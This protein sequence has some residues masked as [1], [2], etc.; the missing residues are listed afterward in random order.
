MKKKVV[1]VLIVTG[2]ILCT[3]GISISS[4]DVSA[5]NDIYNIQF[6]RIKPL[7][8]PADYIN[9]YNN[10]KSK[11][12]ST[13]DKYNSVQSFVHTKDK[14]AF[15]LTNT[16][17]DEE[18]KPGTN[19]L[20]VMCKK[21]NEWYHC[22][23]IRNLSYGH[24]NDMAYNPHDNTIAIVFR[25]YKTK[26]GTIALLDAN[27][28]KEK[29]R[30]K[31]PYIYSAIAYDKSLKRYYLTRGTIKEKRRF[32]YAVC[33][34][35][36]TNCKDSVFSAEFKAV[37]SQ[38]MAAANGYI[39]KINYDAGKNTIYQ[40]GSLLKYRGGEIEVYHYDS[41]KNKYNRVR[42]L[43]FRANQQGINMGEIEGMDFNGDIPYFVFNDILKVDG[44]NTMGRIYTPKYT[45]RNVNA[46]VY[47]KVKTNNKKNFSKINA[48]A[49][50]LSSNPSINKNIAFSNDGYTLSNIDIRTP[51]TYTFKIKQG[52]IKSN[53]WKLD[54]STKTATIR[55]TYSLALNNLTY[56][57][58]FSKG[59]NVFNNNYVYSPIEVPV[60]VNVKTTKKDASYKTPSTKATLYKDGKKIETVSAINGKYTFKKLKF[61]KKGTYKYEIKQEKSGISK[62]GIFTNTIDSS[63]ID[64]TITITEGETVFTTNTKYSKNTFVNKVD[65]D[66]NNVN[67]KVNVKIKTTKSDSEVPTP[68]TQATITKDKT[69]VETVNSANNSYEF[70]ISIKSPGVYKYIIKQNTS[71]T[72]QGI[73]SY[74]LDKTSIT[75][76]ITSK[77]ENNKLVCTSKLSSNTFTNKIAANYEEISVPI[78][79]KIVTQKIPST[80]ETPSTK[81]IIKIGNT[82]KTI[83]NE[84]QY[85]NY[86]AKI[87][88]PGIY[89]Y[90][91]VQKDISNTTD[92]IFD[93]DSKTITYNITVTSSNGILHY[94][95]ESNNDS[96]NNTITSN[97]N[98]LNLSLAIRIETSLPQGINAPITQATL[99]SGETAISTVN[100]AKAR[101]TFNNI[102][103]DT[104]GTYTYKIKQQQTGIVTTDKYIYEYD[105]SEIIVTIIVTEENDKLKPTITYSKNNFNNSVNY[106]YDSISVP[107]KVNIENEKDSASIV[108]PVTTA[109]IYENDEK[110][111]TIQNTGTSY[112]F[113]ILIES[114]GTYIYDIKQD[115]AGIHKTDDYNY[116]LD[117]DTKT[118]I[119]VVTANDGV[120]SAT[121]SFL[122][123]DD[124]F[125]NSYNEKYESI[126]VPL[127]INIETSKKSSTSLPITTAILYEDGEEIEEI[128]NTSNKYIFNSLEFINPGN[129]LYTIKQKNPGKSTSGIYE[130]DIDDTEINV[131]IVITAENGKLKYALN[132]DK[133]EFNNE[134]IV[135]YKPIEIPL[136]VNINEDNPNNLIHETEAI[137]SDSEK[138]LDQVIENNS[139]YKS[140]KITI[141]DEGVYR[142]KI[143]QKKPHNRKKNGI[144]SNL[145]DK[146]ITAVVTATAENDVLK[147]SISYDNNQFNN[148]F[149]TTTEE[150]D[151]YAVIPISVDVYSNTKDINKLEV[152]ATIFD[153]NI[154]IETV[155]L[156]ES[157]YSFNG[158]ELLP[159]TYNYKIKQTNIENPNWQ[160]D[161]EE[162]DIT[163]IVNEDL[164]Y[165]VQFREEISSFTNLDI[166]SVNTSEEASIQTLT[167]VPNTSSKVNYY[168][169]VFGF[170]SIFSGLI[171]MFY[172]TKKCL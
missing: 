136:E 8:V 154:P 151:S 76:T 88:K 153:E 11:N 159:G 149:E 121:T 107:I 71:I 34:N 125:E 86:T 43:F 132:Y 124:T 133:T 42:S 53:N 13:A 105:S 123:Q 62:D 20:Y 147:Y 1:I 24:S 158:L 36:I 32:Y 18:E 78:N 104:I 128:T 54:N 2:L 3:L 129:F 25:D 165:N 33:E 166:N 101:Y 46:K 89:K 87:K 15:M 50:F 148:S 48:K 155:N 57:T 82:S 112:N 116:S 81:A 6:K 98:I 108:V 66:F 52:S 109:S 69:V 39:Y 126:S 83:D 131:E 164:T 65:A 163:I 134:V 80:I 16:E 117:N 145:D 172:N 23:S 29:K 28:F 85:Y 49:N 70:N 47:T 119:V 94:S 10:A 106:N 22:K 72:G 110:K 91:I 150:D 138:V 127:D 103:I 120:L 41:A 122:Y 161:D 75:L 137:I 26:T 63:K 135:H 27:T 130:Y 170:I 5:L 67:N 144:K 114:P 99:F 59:D 14:Y 93:I 115:N 96:F 31:T 4:E 58:S 111:F 55:V 35:S 21:N 77:I 12:K 90:K 95:I 30:V 37:T 139:K 17:R 79:T 169:I 113:S 160:I 146:V 64:L 92:Y 100:S 60:S 141:S 7:Y 9:D 157:I 102:S 167:G 56:S 68:I 73:Y 118:C 162:I 143:R 97:D 74:T 156:N 19:L 140:S 84:G 40:N 171:I 142:F 152:M 61:T 38:G 168:F 51:G 45:P 44:I